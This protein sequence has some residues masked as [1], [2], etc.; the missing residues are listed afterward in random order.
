MWN[1]PLLS[2]SIIHST[3]STFELTNHAP[4]AEFRKPWNVVRA[5]T[6]GRVERTRPSPALTCKR[7]LFTGR[8][9]GAEIRPEPA[10]LGQRVCRSSFHNRLARLPDHSS[11]KTGTSNQI[12]EFT[13]NLWSYF[14]DLTA[15]RSPL[16]S[17]LSRRKRLVHETRR[18]N[19]S[20]ICDAIVLFLCFSVSLFRRCAN[21]TSSLWRCICFSPS[22]AL[23]LCSTESETMI[24]SA[25][26]L[27]TCY[28]K[29]KVQFACYC[30]F[31]WFF[32]CSCPLSCCT[33]QLSTTQHSAVQHSTTQH[34]IAQQSAI[35]HNAVQHCVVQHSAV[36]RSTV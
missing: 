2:Q 12:I 27:L 30:L 31:V 5:F 6:F 35:E 11:E 18:R 29:H 34:S 9:S 14:I 22:Q 15:R 28:I 21:C 19:S 20:R 4:K 7:L 23:E 24:F 16:D 10:A 1:C 36:Q 8:E 17:R 32:V 25:T 13:M 33:I 3:C 26:L